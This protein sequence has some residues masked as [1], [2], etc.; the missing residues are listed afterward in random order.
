LDI[1]KTAGAQIDDEIEVGEKVYLSGNTSEI[2]ADSWD[3][4]RRNKRKYFFLKAPIT[5]HKVSGYKSLSNN[6]KENSQGYILMLDL[7][8]FTIIYLETKHPE[9]DYGIISLKMRKIFT[10]GGM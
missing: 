9:M 4:I 3:I 6:Y 2:A 7:A 5:T 8:E 1:I 10:L